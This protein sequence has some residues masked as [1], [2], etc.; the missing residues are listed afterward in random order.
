MI[1][2]KIVRL[3]LTLT[4]SYC[5]SI[6]MLLFISGMILLRTVV[7][8]WYAIRQIDS[9]GFSEQAHSELDSVFISYGLGSGIPRDVMARQ[10]TPAH[11][12]YAVKG[13]IQ[14]VYG[15]GTGY[16]FEL[17]ADEMYQEFHNFALSQGIS[18]DDTLEEGLRDLSVLCADA[19]KNHVG[20]PIFRIMSET[21][22]FRRAL[23]T[24][25]TLSLAAAIISA[26]FIFIINRRVIKR[27]DGYLYA[28]SAA[29][30]VCA[31]IPIIFFGSGVSK[32]LG[33]TPLSYNQFLSSWLDSIV[34]GYIAALIPLLSLM[35]LCITIRII[36]KKRR[37]R[38]GSL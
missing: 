7:N 15:I 31:A 33:I 19:L 32:R 18:D 5:A 13:S 29:S 16:N 3:A 28:L 21:L 38:R 23:F 17:Y 4:F 36:R 20:S 1:K 2:N 12:E 8:P 10:I 37:R 26:V 27:I 35:A 6:F 14:E 30:A 11:I 22:R 24:G 25:I 34:S 9:S